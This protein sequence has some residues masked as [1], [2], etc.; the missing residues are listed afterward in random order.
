MKNVLF[1]IFLYTIFTIHGWRLGLSAILSIWRY[2]F[3]NIF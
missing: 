3:K 1:A 2:G